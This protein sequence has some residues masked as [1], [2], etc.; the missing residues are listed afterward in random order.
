MNSNTKEKKTKQKTI[1]GK[2]VGSRTV[3]G[4]ICILVALV[5][6]FGI[7]PLINNR[8]SVLTDIV[9]VKQGISEGSI[10]TAND[11]ELVSVGA[12]N[13]PD[14]VIKKTD[15]V[16][17]KYA[18]CDIH[19]GEYILPANVSVDLNNPGSMLDSLD[20]KQKAMSI[21]ISSFA[22]GLSGKLMTGDIIS[23]VVYSQKDG[24]AMT[25]DELQYVKVITTTTSAGIDK[26]DVTD[27]AQPSTVTLLVNQEQAEL[28]A[29]YEKAASM[30]FV[31]E[32][33]GDAATAQ[34]Y[35]DIQNQVFGGGN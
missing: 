29:Q 1:S 34:K 31:L 2:K 27:T 16:V 18:T 11:V 20:G 32:Y 13:L 9:R 30:H 26:A 7:A 33:R 10:I 15:E 14:N 25:P 4:I 17:G 19:P 12:Y 24:F 3:I 35:L 21:T 22:Q 5:V 8:D 6:C 28:L 23:V